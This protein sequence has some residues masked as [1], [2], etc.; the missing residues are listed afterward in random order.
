MPAI[1]IG[2]ICHDSTLGGEKGPLHP[3]AEVLFRH[4]VGS[5]GGMTVYPKIGFSYVKTPFL[6]DASHA[7]LRRHAREI[8]RALAWQILL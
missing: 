4:R 6:G 7:A 2:A 3:V 8:V 1:L 5:E